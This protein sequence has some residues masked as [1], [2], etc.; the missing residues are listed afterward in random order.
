MHEILTLDIGMKVLQPFLGVRRIQGQGQRDL[1][2]DHDI[3]LD[4][5]SRLAFQQTI[6]PELLVLLWWAT[7]VLIKVHKTRKR[8]NAGR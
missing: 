7:E 3:N 5:L 4:S 8:K 2:V 6:Q 1:F